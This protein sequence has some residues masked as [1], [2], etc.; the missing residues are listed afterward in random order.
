MLS[1]LV[2]GIS[3]IEPFLKKRLEMHSTERYGLRKIGLTGLWTL[4]I[5]INSPAYSSENLECNLQLKKNNKILSISA[6]ISKNIETVEIRIYSSRNQKIST[7]REISPYHPNPEEQLNRDEPYDRNIW[8]PVVDI[9][10]ERG[11]EG[12][13]LFENINNGICIINGPFFKQKQPLQSKIFIPNRILQHWENSLF[14][15]PKSVRLSNFYLRFNVPNITGFINLNLKLLSAQWNGKV[16]L[17]TQTEEGDSLL[18]SKELVWQELKKPEFEKDNSL[19]R[20]R[21]LAALEATI[22]FTLR[23]Q[24]KDPVNPANGGLYLFYDLDA[25][26]FRSYHWIWGWGP[27]VKMLLESAAAVPSITN[28]NQLVQAALEIGNSSLN[29][30]I[31]D[32]N[33]PVNQLVISRWDRNL[34]LD[35]G[36]R[37]AVTAADALFLGGWAWVPLYEV[38]GDNK[39]REATI[40]QCDVTSKLLESWDIIPHSYYFE[41]EEWG[42]GVI[43]ETGFGMEGFAELYRVTGDSKY[44]QNGKVYIDR[45]IRFF[46][47]TDGLWNRNYNFETKKISETQYMT[48]GLAWAFE[49]LLAAHRLLPNGGYLKKAEKMAIEIS[50][51]QQSSGCWNFRY[52][53]PEEK[54]GKSEKG[55]AIWSYFFYQLYK[56]TGNENYLQT[57]R[58]ALRWCLNNLYDGTDIEAYG[59]IVGCSSASGVGYRRWFKVS[60][61]YTSA[62]FGLA[63]L[64][65]LALPEQ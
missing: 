40:W 30:I 54:V 22:N 44:Q 23:S 39:F 13:A 17:L 35:T 16:L 48:R 6:N 11:M 2:I 32:S 1:L 59:S 5:L 14:V 60:C 29:F 52:M 4:A 26:L 31:R 34:S 8:Y 65:E 38:I 62:F 61:T 53:E 7:I 19:N 20:N 15:E 58:A 43:D 36:Y 25:F 55:T 50:R 3:W 24:I 10:I 41:K 33:S 9:E 57:A 46:E 64:E 12:V 45:H 28:P 37:G 63:L 27:S 42:N 56:I 49:G 47:R 21:L 18:C 51:W